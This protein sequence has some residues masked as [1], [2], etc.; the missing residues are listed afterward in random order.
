MNA[1]SGTP[2]ASEA[3][4]PADGNGDAPGRKLRGKERRQRGR[5]ES[6]G[7][8]GRSGEAAET[9]GVIVTGLGYADPNPNLKPSPSA[10]PSPSNSP[11]PSP[12]ASPDPNSDPSPNPNQVC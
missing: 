10:D 6:E 8:G 11:N 9:P 7:G 2:G 3:A 1:A 4:T 5:R 12:S